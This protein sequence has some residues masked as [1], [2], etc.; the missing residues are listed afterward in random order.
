MKQGVDPDDIG[1]TSGVTACLWRE[2]D[3]E[4]V[5]EPDLD[6]VAG[7]HGHLDYAASQTRRAIP[8]ETDCFRV[9]PEKAFDLVAH[10]TPLGLL[11]QSNIDAVL[12]HVPCHANI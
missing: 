11:D 6:C 2:T 10:S 1:R 9:P 7:S 8:G 3:E 5:G 12:I 4:P